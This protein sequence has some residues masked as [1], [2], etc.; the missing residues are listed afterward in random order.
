MNREYR[1]A[2][3]VSQLYAQL[4]DA[5]AE[6]EALQARVAALEAEVDGLIALSRAYL[7]QL[8]R[9]RASVWV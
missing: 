8:Q 3:E 6:I 2:C 4:S 5:Q 7:E 9:T 1:Q